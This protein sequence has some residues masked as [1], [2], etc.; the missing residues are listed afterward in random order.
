M[1]SEATMPRMTAA[2]LALIGAILSAAALAAEIKVGEAPPKLAPGGSFTVTFPDLPATFEEL[3]NAKGVKPQM[4]VCLPK[5]YDPTAK[6]PLLIFLGGGTGG[7]GGNP[8][9]A[10]A[11]AEDTDFVCASLPLFHKTAPGEAGYD[12]IVREADGKYMWP[13]H[14]KML[15][16]LDRVVPNIDPAHRVIGGFSNGGHAVQEML[17]QSDGEMAKMFSAFFLVNG[18]GRLQK[19]ELIKGKP[20]MIAYGGKAL[21]PER[22]AEMVAAAK[23]G[24]VELTAYEMK[25]VGHAFPEAEYPAVRKWLRG[26]ALGRAQENPPPG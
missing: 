15:A 9:V 26:P 3:V 10:R 20:L 2:A 11:L 6:H 4:T 24:G 7:R 23:A 17:E 13:F 16:E 22:L 18:G 19:Y 21:R 1:S 8:S 5:N 14:K 12:L 25:D